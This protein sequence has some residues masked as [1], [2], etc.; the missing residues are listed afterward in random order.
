MRT[1]A[2]ACAASTPVPSEARA[3]VMRMTAPRRRPQ[4]REIEGTVRLAP[5]ALVGLLVGIGLAFG[6]NVSGV[7]LAFYGL[8]LAV[9]L[10]VVARRLRRRT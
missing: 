8:V 5:A 9:L 7:V 1:I 3:V 4:C 2:D 6:T 10:A